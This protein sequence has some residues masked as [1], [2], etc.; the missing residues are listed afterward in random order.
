MK[1]A[2]ILIF[3]I[4]ISNLVFGQIRVVDSISNEGVPFVNIRFDKDNGVYTDDNGEFNLTDITKNNIFLS[5]I[6]YK[7]K[8]VDLKVIK[9]NIIYLSPDNY[10][11]DEVIISKKT[12]KAKTKKIKPIKHNDFL[13]SHRL[14]VGGELAVLILN[15]FNSNDVELKSLL[16]PVITKTISFDNSMSGKVQRV[17]RL[18]F[19]ALY[20][21]TFYENFGG[22]PGRQIN[23]EN[24]TI[25]LNEKSTIANLNLEKYNIN[26]PS[27]GVFIGILNLG[28][29]DKNGKLV[30]TSPFEIRKG[31]NGMVKVVKPTKPYFPVYYK[32]NKNKTF[33]RYTFEENKDWKIFYRHGKVKSGEHHYISVG[34]EVKIY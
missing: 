30:S 13:K 6:G 31:K 26:L 25:V 22:E 28:K 3:L 7:N 23:Y 2:F 15:N 1:K 32:E 34:Y 10:E 27:E 24:I 21:I 17:K 19:S 8:T 29:T 33:S 4:Q 11:L 20:K 5:S 18:P 12:K 16:I 14:I 9:N